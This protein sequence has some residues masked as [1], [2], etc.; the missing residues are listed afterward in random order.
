MYVYSYKLYHHQYTY[1]NC[2]HCYI[3]AN[4]LSLLV[5]D[6]DWESWVKNES[7][8]W[9]NQVEKWLHY[10]K[11]PV[12]IAGYDNLMNDTYSELKKILDFIEYPYTEDDIECAVNSPAEAFHRHHTKK[13]PN[14]YPPD[15][16]NYVLNRIKEID[17]D[18]LKHN[19]SIYFA[20]KEA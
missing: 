10:R 6:S 17:A 8:K 16:Q 5:N 15:L 20:Y 2:V 1:N 3:L 19:I 4:Y 13:Y 7:D 18:L 14:L 12:L 9:K 11:V